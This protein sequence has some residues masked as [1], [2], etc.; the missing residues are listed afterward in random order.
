MSRIRGRDTKPEIALRKSLHARGFRYRTNARE[1]PGK[2][3]LVFP[4]YRA[5]VLVHGCFW[6][7][8]SDC[9]LSTTPN[10]NVEFWVN[11][12]QGTVERDR[13]VLNELLGKG[14]RIA[15][16]WQCALSK[17]ELNLTSSLIEEWLKSDERQKEIP[18]NLGD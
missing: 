18:F 6:H 9:R 5:I 1:I 11:K 17:R 15:T 14:W 2:P 8:H 10:S 7:R 16:V 12:F 4:R 3:D 13:R